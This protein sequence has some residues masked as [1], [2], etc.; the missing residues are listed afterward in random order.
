MYPHKDLNMVEFSKN[1]YSSRDSSLE[2]IELEKYLKSKNYF[3]P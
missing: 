1:E 3:K 2:Y